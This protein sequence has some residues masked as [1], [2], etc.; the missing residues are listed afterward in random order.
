MES[1]PPGV[2]EMGGRRAI[3]C[4]VL[5]DG[6]GAPAMEDVVL[7]LEG[8]R[9]RSIEP[10]TDGAGRGSQWGEVIE[11]R[12]HTVMP[13]L[14]DAH[15]HLCLGS[16]TS[17]SWAAA[18]SDSIGIVGWGLASGVAAL[19]CGITTVVDAGSRDG[20][21][22]RVATLIESGLAVGPR[23][24]AAGA[25]ITTTAGHGSDFGV[26][27]DNEAEVV[28]AVRH[29]VAHGADLIKIMV[30]GGAIYPS[31][32]RRRSQYT[33]A[34]LK[35]GIDD[36][37]RLGKRVLGHANATEGITRAVNAGIDMVAHCNWL[38]SAPGTLEL[39][40]ETIATMAS[41]HVWIDLNIEGALRDMTTTDGVV[42][43]WPF[44]NPEPKTRWDLLQPLRQLGVKLY[45]TSDAF[46]P[47]VGGFTRSLRDGRCRWGLSAEELIALVS[48]EPACALGVDDW[49]GT[50]APGKLA[51]MVVLGGD[52]RSDPDAIVR[53]VSVYRNGVEV[54]SDGR[55]LP[56]AVS[57]ASGAEEAAQHTLLEA[58]FEE[59]D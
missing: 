14:I 6:S 24:L 4:G 59:L 12:G 7:V 26:Q 1:D 36:A 21:A 51:D 8:A 13:G 2:S 3:R 50:L 35:A 18:S 42:V 52:L 31:T 37:H 20:L 25:A 48:G 5:I 33:Q 44:A 55:L 23:I 9:V 57:M 19:R 45:L 58:V 56:A 41:N 53:P 46:G 28:A 16:P 38:G 10:W 34:E 27:A 40:V 30:T 29:A 54:V 17:P 49:L 43:S 15:V 47:S 11:L 39:D 22:L 32:N